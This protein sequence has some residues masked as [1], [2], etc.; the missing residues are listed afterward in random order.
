[1]TRHIN[2]IAVIGRTGQVARS[3]ISSLRADGR[4][5]HVLAR[6]TVD[7]RDPLNC[8][9]AIRSIEPD[10]VINCAAY[11]LVD[12]AETDPRQALMINAS[13]AQA[14][15][16]AAALVAA[17]VIHFSTDY[18]FD[19]TK[20]SPYVETDTPNPKTM[21]G[22]SKFA[23]DILVAS[24][25]PEH[26]ILRTAWVNS[27]F[28]CNFIRS[29][30]RLARERATVSV[31]DD[32]LGS[33][34]FAEDLARCVQHIVRRLETGTN[35]RKLFSVF[36][37]VNDGEASWYELARATMRGLADRG[38][39]AADVVPIPSD[40]YPTRATRPRYSVLDI[41]K[42]RSVYGISMRCWREALSDCLDAM[43]MNEKRPMDGELPLVRT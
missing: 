7:L 31:V 2:R 3:I 42:L 8:T 29:M 5:V 11:T 13:G 19:G 15:A 37:A 22:R 34:T 23:G 25:N 30:Q 40:S 10:I 36:N 41:G 4:D 20:R 21:Y 24:A 16:R 14:V 1:M 9:R 26:I 27:P 35:E 33:P 39:P 32:Q 28:G 6:P 12:E 38:E 17:P 18:V 43:A